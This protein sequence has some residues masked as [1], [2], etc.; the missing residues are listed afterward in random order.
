MSARTG[1]SMAQITLHWAIVALI[2]VQLLFNDGVQQGFDDRM[3]GTVS[4]DGAW[5]TLHIG[6]G[7]CVLVLATLRLGLRLTRGAPPPPM[8][9]PAIVT[10]AGILAHLAL[11]LLMFAM[12]LTGAIAWFGHREIAAELHELGRLL[13]IPLIGLHVLGA[14]AEHFVFGQNT[15]LRMFRTEA[16]LPRKVASPQR[17]R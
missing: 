14:L 11:Y 12:P 17:R 2:G 15:L 13:L 9:N 7:L 4:A 8:G 10:W 16:N 6:V 1:Y 5:A 3:N